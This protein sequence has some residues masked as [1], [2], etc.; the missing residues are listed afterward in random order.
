MLV[1]SVPNM[2]HSMITGSWRSMSKSVSE[3]CKGMYI[4]EYEEALIIR[5]EL[6]QSSS[7]YSFADLVC[8]V[9]LMK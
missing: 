8:Y 7:E 1:S 3:K 6:R 4:W 9:C 5:D 2:F